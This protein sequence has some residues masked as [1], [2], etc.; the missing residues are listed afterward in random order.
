M[1]E[2]AAGGDFTTHHYELAYGYDRNDRRRWMKHPAALAPVIGGTR[3]DS[4]AYSYTTHG[5]LETVRDVT[6]NVFRYHYDAEGRLDTLTAPGEAHEAFRYDAD[7]RLVRR[8]DYA[9]HYRPLVGGGTRDSTLHWDMLDHEARGKVVRAVTTIDTTGLLLFSQHSQ[10]YAALGAVVRSWYRNEV[11]PFQRSDDVYEVDALGNRRREYPVG[12][13]NSSADRNSSYRAGTG[14]LWTTLPVV[15]G[16]STEET[17][18]DA[19]GNRELYLMNEGGTSVVERARYYYGADD[20]L[21]IADRRSCVGNLAGTACT[22]A[23]PAYDRRG[24][25]EEYRYDA[26]GRRVWRRSR[27]E[28]ATTACQPTAGCLNFVERIVWDGDQLLYEIRAPGGSGASATTLERDAGLAGTSGP[29]GEQYFG[30]V[31]YM[32]G[33]GIDRPLGVMRLDYSQTYAAPL[34]VVPHTTWLGRYDAGTFADGIGTPSTIA[35]V[36][37]GHPYCQNPASNAT[38]VLIYWP[39]GQRNLFLNNTPP[40]LDVPPSWFGSLILDQRDGSGQYYR[41]NRYYDPASG[42]FTQEDPIGLAGRD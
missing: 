9:K 25:F 14:R 11:Y 41:R 42:R 2:L 7:D 18:Y 10:G 40:Q 34:V 17:L 32:H 21:R 12:A 29:E 23:T 35:P 38:C 37:P 19:A 16:G 4:V 15:G 3:R 26:L 6:G 8:W 31:A 20:Q 33:L 27:Q 5:A 30:R 13:A 36:P 39:G 24:A 1:A 22:T 28:E